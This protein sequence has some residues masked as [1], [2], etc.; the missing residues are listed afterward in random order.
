MV[1]TPLC[2]SDVKRTSTTSCHKGPMRRALT[3]SVLS[4]LAAASLAAPPALAN[5]GK[6]EKKAPPTYFALQPLT[7]TTIRRDGRRGS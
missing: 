4:L 7:A 5:S 3:L 6:A 2:P 1:N